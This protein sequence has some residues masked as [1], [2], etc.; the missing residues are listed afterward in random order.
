MDQFILSVKRGICDVY[1]AFHCLRFFG[2]LFLVFHQ[3]MLFAK[4]GELLTLRLRKM[5]FEAILRQVSKL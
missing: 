1:S 2:L 4:S 5:A 3:T